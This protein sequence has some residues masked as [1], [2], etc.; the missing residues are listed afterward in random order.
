MNSR[1]LIAGILI[2]VAVLCAAWPYAAPSPAPL[3]ESPLDLRGLFIG[4]DAAKDAATTAGLTGELA[5]AIELDG[6]PSAAKPEP[7]LR[8]GA[9]FDDL[10]RAAREIRCR[11][12]SLGAR[13]PKVRDAIKAYLDA[14][15]GTSGGPVDAAGRVAWVY[16]LR[17]V[18]RAAEAAAR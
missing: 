2:G 7:R 16:A 9:A 3:P 8:T 14:K 12:E 1:A 10:R 4:S 13:Q 17:D 6:I 15:V 11:G 18:S 5:D